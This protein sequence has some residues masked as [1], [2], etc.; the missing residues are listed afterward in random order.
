MI[1]IQKILGL[2]ALAMQI[3]FLLVSILNPTFTFATCLNVIGPRWSRSPPLRLQPVTSLDV[4][5]N[6]LNRPPV[7]ASL[8]PQFCQRAT[9][10][11][12]RVFT[13]SGCCHSYVMPC[14]GVR[15]GVREMLKLV[16]LGHKN[17]EAIY[18][19]F[20]HS[21]IFNSFFVLFTFSNL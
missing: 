19:S 11:S 14:V 10:G 2:T 20:C 16:P 8:W 3:L 21:S 9:E 4:I 17:Q 1:F 6:S 18:N 13:Q 7:T 5:S 12:T 15:T